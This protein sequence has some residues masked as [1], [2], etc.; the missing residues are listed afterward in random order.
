MIKRVITKSANSVPKHVAPLF[1][2]FVD[3]ESLAIGLVERLVKQIHAIMDQRG[4]C[5]LVF[6]GGHSLRRILELLSAQDLPWAALHLYPSD[7]RCVPVGD[8][9]RNDRLID[10]MLLIQV[11]LPP[12][13]L[14]RIPAELGPEEGASYYSQLLDQTPRFDI[15]LL[16]V[17]PDGHIA[18]LFPGHSALFD[19]R[20]AVPVYNAPK[21]PPERVSIG[22]AR[23]LAARERW[24]IVIG[25]EKRDLIARMQR[26]EDL[27][28]IRMHPTAFYV[29]ENLMPKTKSR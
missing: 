4:T 15:V 2:R 28:V 20:S 19:N 17:G 6:P 26:K 9:E 5:H 7:E 10:E 8:P 3:A 24:V 18:S 25:V 23:L 14:H 11:P 1:Y 13:N 12:E 21:P 27:P 22:M 29:E 16:G